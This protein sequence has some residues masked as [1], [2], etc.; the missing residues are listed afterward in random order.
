MRIS[1]RL[2]I[3]SIAAAAALA[4][5]GA[6]GLMGVRHIQQELHVMTSDIL[7][8][9]NK[10][11]QL[12]QHKEQTLRALLALSHAGHR[13][14]AAG[15]NSEVEERLAELQLSSDSLSASDQV[16]TV[17]IS[18]FYTTRDGI[19]HNIE[20]SYA[21]QDTYQEAAKKAQ[22][23]LEKASDSVDEVS[24]GVQAIANDANVSAV[25]ARSKSDELIAQQRQAHRINQLLSSINVL[26]YEVDGAQ[27]KYKLEPARE[28]FNTLFTELDEIAKTTFETEELNTAIH[29]V[30]A[31][32]LKFS[33]EE[34][35]LFD[36]K[37]SVLAK[38]PKT[39]FAY[40]K[41]LRAV[42]MDIEAASAA[43]SSAIARLEAEI[44]LAN[45]NIGAALAFSSDPSSITA[46]NRALILDTRDLRIE[47]QPLFAA[48]DIRALAGEYRQ[49]SKKIHALTVL[50]FRLSDE[51]MKQELIALSD[52]SD[53]IGDE[54]DEVQQ[55]ISAVNN[56]KRATFSSQQA[57]K[58]SIVALKQVS[59]SQR[60]TGQERVDSI[61]E[62]LADVISAVDD[63]VSQSTSLI[64]LISVAAILFSAAFSFITIK[65][66][67]SRLQRALQVAET[68]SSGDL[69]PVDPSEHRDEVSHVL[70]A[71]ARMVT[72]LDG[73]V[74]QIRSASASVNQGAEEIDNSN[75]ALTRRNEQQ[76]QH[77]ND[78]ANSTRN[79]SELMKTGAEAVQ[80]VSDLSCTAANTAEQGRAVVNQAMSTMLS[81]E[82]GSKEISN[83]I[84]VIDSISFQTNILA[85]N[86][87]V[88]ASRAGELGRGFAVVA[89]EVRALASKSKEAATQI[90]EIIANN[91]A[92]VEA[93][94]AL[95]NDAG[96]R[97]EDVVQKVG[98][99]RNLIEEISSA[100]K[101]QVE[102]IAHIDAS[103]DEIESMTQQNASLSAENSG[104]AKNLLNQARQLDQAVS[105]FQL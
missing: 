21:G 34:K 14:E 82:N 72:M 13:D 85:L 80:Q 42:T 101:M 48:T 65:A 58:D 39:K 81:I 84:S 33:A 96:Q 5:V 89:S 59:E 76:A 75:T 46:I 60:E 103:V 78:T 47:L 40:R 61:N 16:G 52:L 25:G 22:S 88:E 24:K 18:A 53:S 105:V 51:L 4:G 11:L 67:L 49:A 32:R 3:Q 23:S 95:V 90:K 63:K 73:S 38:T 15:L 74:R 54:L 93:G 29:S 37:L 2:I 10:L 36:L 27:S 64:I 7:P 45:D 28:K 50:S 66:I 68:V 30:T 92:D 8:L 97:M 35:G 55:A 71:L 41:L 83:I 86:A 12:E 62:K 100:S 104:S 98:E 19:N 17:D 43:V 99:V 6:L 26:L 31:I 20:T 9:K 69:S 79:V 70:D 87:A 102:S 57:L 94:T 91:V 77:L 44:V 56:G 1:T